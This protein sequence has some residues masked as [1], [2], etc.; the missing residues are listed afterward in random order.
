MVFGPMRMISLKSVPG[1]S[2]SERKLSPLGLRRQTYS[3]RAGIAKAASEST[4][5]RKYRDRVILILHHSIPIVAVLQARTLLT[6]VEN[7]RRF[8]YLARRFWACRPAPGIVDM[9]VAN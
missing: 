1:P 3:A 8:R 7:C 9:L 4:I 5:V 6:A 2:R